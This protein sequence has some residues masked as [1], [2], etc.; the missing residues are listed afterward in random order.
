MHRRISAGQVV[1]IVFTILLAAVLPAFAS[2]L[3]YAE[4]PDGGDEWSF[5]RTLTSRPTSTPAA[6]WPSTPVRPLQQTA[7]SLPLPPGTLFPDAFAGA[8]IETTSELDRSRTMVTIFVPS[9]P[10]GTYSA[11]VTGWGEYDLPCQAV[12]PGSKHL[13]CIGSRLPTSVSLTLI[14][15]QT[16]T[17]RP[18]FA[19]FQ[20]S[21]TIPFLP[22]SP[23]GAGGQTGGGPVF[24][25]STHTPL[26]SHTPTP[27]PTATD[28]LLPPT[29]TATL[30]PSP[31][32]T[33][34]PP[35]PTNTAVPPSPTDTDVPPT[36]T[37]TDVPPTPTD[38]PIP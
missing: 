12:R 22:A 25:T 37:D 7:V 15:Y 17:G 3:T 11:R 29:P 21:F 24:P 1:V 4:T 5:S 32:D 2:L 23:A 31:T 16:S 34:V 18:A 27:P 33:P 14:L 8:T 36:P 38:T 35:T 30:S 20:S 10:Q 13:Y 6:E 26:P 28:T 9:D 19:V